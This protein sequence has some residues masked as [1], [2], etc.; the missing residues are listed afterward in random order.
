MYIPLKSMIRMYRSWPHAVP[1]SVAQGSDVAQG[2]EESRNID[3]VYV[4]VVVK[5][6]DCATYHPSGEVQNFGDSRYRVVR[7]CSQ[8]HLDEASSFVLF[9]VYQGFG[10]CANTLGDEYALALARALELPIYVLSL[11]CPKTYGEFQY[12][13]NVVTNAA[14]RGKDP[15]IDCDTLSGSH[16][17]GS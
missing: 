11:T 3:E 1:T 17:Y 14:E 10:S 15:N 16:K 9:T 7:V 6:S 13:W 2:S 5:S 12:L 4:H 8:R